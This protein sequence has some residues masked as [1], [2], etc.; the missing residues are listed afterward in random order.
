MTERQRSRSG[1]A[2][3]CAYGALDEFAFVD[4]HDS[5]GRAE[6]T[7]ADTPAAM[8]RVGA[9]RV[10]RWLTATRKVQERALFHWSIVF[11]GHRTWL[12]VLR[13]CAQPCCRPAQ[14]VG[15]PGDARPGILLVERDEWRELGDRR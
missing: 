5:G 6:N 8:V 1:H 12:S 4:G 2:R 7:H 9:A 13:V 14:A 15:V 10:I 11:V 3:A